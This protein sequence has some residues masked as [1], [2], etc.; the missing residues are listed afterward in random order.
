MNGGGE[1]RGTIGLHPSVEP[2]PF[3]EAAGLVWARPMARGKD[4]GRPRSALGMI[5]AAVAEANGCVV[6]TDNE[7]D[8]ADVDFV[9]PLRAGTR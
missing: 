2:L 9:N 8:F 3:D 1:F 7:K 6:A 5:I 4:A